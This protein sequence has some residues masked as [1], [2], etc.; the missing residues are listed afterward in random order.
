MDIQ[1]PLRMIDGMRKMVNDPEWKSQFD[2]LERVTKVCWPTLTETQQDSLY[3]NLCRKFMELTFS[4][5]RK[6][7]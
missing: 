3:T 6:I 7:S 4:F 5:Q 2:D 1:K